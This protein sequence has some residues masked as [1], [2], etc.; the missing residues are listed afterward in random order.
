MPKTVAG[1]SG[2]S[3]NVPLEIARE[4]DRP[5][6][7][8]SE[9]EMSRFARAA[10]SMSVAVHVV[11][12]ATLYYGLPHLDLD[13]LEERARP[14][15]IRVDVVF[16]GSKDDPEVLRAYGTVSW[17]QQRMG[18]GAG[19]KRGNSAGEEAPKTV[20]TDSANKDSKVGTSDDGKA[21]AP[22]PQ[23]QAASAKPTPPAKVQAN[24]ESSPKSDEQ[25]DKS[26]PKQPFKSAA[27]GEESRGAAPS[28]TAPGTPKPDDIVQGA[29][30]AKDKEDKALAAKGKATRS[31]R[32]PA[33]RTPRPTPRA[34]R[35]PPPRR[36]S[37]PTSRPPG[38]V[39]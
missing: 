5:A 27:P 24:P 38:R 7:V 2:E 21:L 17:E 15:N 31:I 11:A 29:K 10:V 19:S 22:L 14:E 6:Q 33:N 4:D 12:V 30:N 37:A 34:G 20:A 35:P 26:T 23:K 13:W 28:Q 36:A 39:A 8:E 32:S 25:A 16:Y 1:E 3:V 18:L 9:H